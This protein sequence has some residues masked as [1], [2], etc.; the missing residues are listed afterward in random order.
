MR[1]PRDISKKVDVLFSGAD[2]RNEVRDLL[3]GLWGTNVIV[4]PDQL[5]RSI[6]VL[7]DGDLEEFR[8]LFSSHFD[9]DPR[10]VVTAAEA[11]LGWPGHYLNRPF[12]S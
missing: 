7:C 9:G 1:L 4:G 8:R 5:A 12:E 6:L 10:D 2:E 11:K 3:A